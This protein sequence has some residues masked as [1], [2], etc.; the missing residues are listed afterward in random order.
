VTLLTPVAGLPESIHGFAVISANSGP[1]T[2]CGSG[3]V[4]G[5]IATCTCP[6][7]GCQICVCK[8]NA[9]TT[10]RTQSNG[11]IKILTE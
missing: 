11:F 2:G 10:D 9:S 8:P 1:A 7:D 4:P 5:H 6:A 3:G